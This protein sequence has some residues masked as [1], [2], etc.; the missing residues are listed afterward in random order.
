MEQ[1]SHILKLIGGK[2]LVGETSYHE[3]YSGL[4]RNQCNSDRSPAERC[5][6]SLSTTLAT[7]TAV[8]LDVCAAMNNGDGAV[9]A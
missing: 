9:D 5:E 1:S 3:G 8:D 6:Q 4:N 7:T 2:Y